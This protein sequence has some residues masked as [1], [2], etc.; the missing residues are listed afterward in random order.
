MQSFMWADRLKDKEAAA[1]AKA[2]GEK[3]AAAM[4]AE[5][6][7]SVAQIFETRQGAHH[8]ACLYSCLDRPFK[9]HGIW[10]PTAK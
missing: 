1:E 8:R 6:A 5:P 3:F 4:Q 2:L 10:W 9:V 7:T